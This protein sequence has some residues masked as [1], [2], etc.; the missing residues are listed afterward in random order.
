MSDLEKAYE[1]I[2]F[3]TFREGYYYWTKNHPDD[4]YYTPAGVGGGGV[5]MRLP[6]RFQDTARKARTKGAP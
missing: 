1:L 2:R 3:L 5:E 4:W 6:D